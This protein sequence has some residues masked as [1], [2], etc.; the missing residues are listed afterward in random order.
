MDET[1]R[2]A[3]TEPP[4]WGRLTRRAEFQR[5]IGQENTVAGL[6]VLGEALVSGGGAF[7][8]PQYRFRGDGELGALHQSAATLGET[9]EP[10]LGTLQVEQDARVNA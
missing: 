1:A 6:N 5:A 4:K 9:A 2:R 7:D 3:P 10:D 8:R